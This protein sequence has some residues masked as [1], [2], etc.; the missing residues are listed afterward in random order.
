MHGGPVFDIAWYCQPSGVGH[1]QHLNL[2]M[3]MDGWMDGSN[4]YQTYTILWLKYVHCH[5]LCQSSTAIFHNL[6]LLTTT[7]LHLLWWVCFVIFC[8]ICMYIVSKNVYAST[9]F[10][11][12]LLCFSAMLSGSSDSMWMWYLYFSGLLRGYSVLKLLWCKLSHFVGRGTVDYP[13]SRTELKKSLIV[14]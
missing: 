2:N 1:G 9:W 5:F 12:P 10:S 6:C 4:R 3:D 14:C 11:C 13:Q 8:I 7:K